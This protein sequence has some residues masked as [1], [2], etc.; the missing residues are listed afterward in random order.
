[1]PTLSRKL[2]ASRLALLPDGFE[3]LPAQVA[4]LEERSKAFEEVKGD[5]K[6][7]LSKVEEIHV[8]MVLRPTFEN[9]KTCAAPLVARVEELEKIKAE[10]K[11]GWKVAT[12]SASVV[13]GIITAGYYLVTVLK[14]FA[15]PK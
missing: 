5:V 8:G 15:H 14:D 11:A 1:M 3:K 4:V 10:A 6:T 9:C 12:V 13:G 2:Q 7:L